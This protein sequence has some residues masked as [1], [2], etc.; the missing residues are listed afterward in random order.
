MTTTKLTQMS[1]HRVDRTQQVLPL[2][3]TVSLLH[4]IYPLTACGASHTV[5]DQVFYTLIMLA[6]IFFSRH[7]RPTL[8]WTLGTAAHFVVCGSFGYQ[9]WRSRPEGEQ[10]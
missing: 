8:Q 3:V 10:S 7:S 4:L 9:R 6:G 5:I 2:L 1:D